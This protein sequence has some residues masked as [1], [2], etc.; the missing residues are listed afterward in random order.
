MAL[1]DYLKQTQRFL[2]D[3][4]QEFNDPADLIDYVNR[5][6]REIAMRAQ[7][8]RVLTPISG[9][10]IS[11]SV[12]NAGTGYTSTPT[13]TISDPDFPS[14]TLPFPNGDQATAAA[15]VS[16]GSVASIDVTYGGYGYFQ[17]TATILGGGGT[18]ATATLAL[19]YI[20]QLAAG[21]EVYA[22][23]SVDLSS[24]PGVQSVYLIKSVSLLY[25]NYRYSLACPSFSSYQASLR[26]Y[27]LQYQYVPFYCAQYGQGTA[28]SF[29][30]YPLPSQAYQMEWDTLCL[31]Q[32]LTDDQSV[33]ALPQPWTE[34]V[35]YFAAHLAYLELQ[36]H[37]FARGYK[38]LFD[39]F[40][41]RY[42]VYARPGRVSNP[43]GRP[44]W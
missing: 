40:M 5:A 38:E 39:E 12:T 11:A 33:E 42:S 43:Y 36:N 13:V 34:A 18:G 15:I 6:R 41:H 37:N 21:Q 3:A 20:N 23:S 31:P 19:S 35:P 32:D 7:C 2:R 9:Q 22:F 25:S 8:L 30:M 26:A 1:F 24:F 16:G 29:F 14:G 28:G 44:F 27:P 17:P 10:C 4:R